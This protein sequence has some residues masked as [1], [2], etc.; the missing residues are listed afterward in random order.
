MASILPQALSAPLKQLLRRCHQALLPGSCLLCG[1]DAG[2]GLLC[3]PCQDEL[4]N[5][6]VA[7][8][9]QCAEATALGERCG[10]CLLEPPHYAHVVPRWRYEFPIDRLIHALKYQ[11]Q[12]AIARWLGEQMAT[13]LPPGEH[14]LIPMPLHPDRLRQRGFNQAREIARSLARHRRLPLLADILHRQRP[15][16]PQADLDQRQ[17]RRNVRNAF[18]CTV[19][20]GG[21]P[22]I[23]VDDVLTTGATANECAR[24]L[25]LHGAGP[26]TVAVAARA[27]KQRSG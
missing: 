5:S 2:A 13:T 20:L 19:D 9:P 23:L 12:T 1:S 3:P 6:P 21:K 17:R 11:H 8:C 15:T 14:W 18:A 4:P 22:I 7:A 16:A 24:I 27:L 25:Q 10:A 26:I